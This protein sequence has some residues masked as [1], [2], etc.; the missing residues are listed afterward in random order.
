MT[1]SCIGM[2]QSASRVCAF[3]KVIGSKLFVGRNHSTSENTIQITTKVYLYPKYLGKGEGV[4][5]NKGEKRNGP[6]ILCHSRLLLLR[7]PH[8]TQHVRE[9]SPA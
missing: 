4:T 9:R 6:A 3:C 5:L 2:D 8:R 7:F 1:V